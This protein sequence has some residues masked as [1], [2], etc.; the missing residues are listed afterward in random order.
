MSDAPGESHL[1][2]LTASA[3]PVLNAAL[4]QNHVPVISELVV[5]NA[6][7]ST[8]D[9][10]SIDLSM[11]PPILL[12]HVWRIDRLA[13]GQSMR[14]ADLDVQLDGA[15]LS[16]MSEAV[17]GSLSFV[18]KGAGIP[19]SELRRDISVLAFNEW[20]GTRSIPDILAAFVQPND[21]AVTRIAR[22]ASDLLRQSGK[23]DGM[24][25]YQQSKARAWEQAQAIWGAVCRLDIRYIN[26]PPSFVAGGQRI[27]SPERIVEE[28]LGTCLDLA[29]LFAACLEYVGL[30]PLI[31]LQREHAFAGL[32]L[33]KGDFGTSTV[34]D[35]PGLR[36]RRKLDDLLLFETTLATTTPKPSFR[37]AIDL[38]ANRIAPEQ[39]TAFEVVIDIHRA[40]QRRIL[41]L[42]SPSAG[43]ALQQTAG[44]PEDAA[45]PMEAPPALREDFAARD[46]EPPPATR[47]DRVN[48]WRKR[49]L[50]LSG[51]NRLLNMR[52]TG[53]QTLFIDCPD[54]AALGEMLA[55]MHGRAAGA[56]LRFRAWPDLMDGTDPRSAVLHRDRLLEDANVAFAR[57]AMARRELLVGR[58]E[59]R[60]CGRI[61]PA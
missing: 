47:E 35:A 10:I 37:Q 50:D 33:S 21:P 31:V 3:Q 26:P 54:P 12:P 41:P 27:R 44:E 32:W 4:W 52:S 9:D 43:Y 40:R 8:I 14:L 18:V 53:R 36:T 48:R 56:P 19:E 49:L 51:R 39:D 61:S 46:E 55:A 16:G 60:P 28:R 15:M 30:R 2:D 57:Q 38:G 45:P 29:V 6:S 42:A 1:I 11:T 25:G 34:D 7:Q 59:A 23:P 22:Q 13:A 17:R 24:E 58:D 5:T 20:G